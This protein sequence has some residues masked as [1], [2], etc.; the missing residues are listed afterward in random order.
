MSEINSI[1]SDIPAVAWG[2]FGAIIGA[3]I[4]FIGVLVSNYGNNNRLNIQLTHDAKEKSKDRINTLRREVYLSA[5]EEMSRASAY[6]GSIS[7][8]DLATANIAMDLQNLFASAAKLS[9]VA[10][11]KT[12]MAVNDLGMLYS[13]LLMKLMIQIEPIQQ[14]KNTISIQQ[15]LYDTAHNNSMRVMKELNAF[16]ETAQQDN[17]IFNA[18]TRS[19]ESFSNTAHYHSDQLIIA[20][21]EHCKLNF[22]FN[23]SLLPAIKE[24]GLAQVEVAICIRQ[25]LGLNT[26]A[27]E[28]REQINKQWRDVQNNLDNTLETMAKT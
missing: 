23:K 16:V 20:H 15:N 22:E 14:I 3:S 28:L 4:A 10:E 8:L 13:T 9:L 1:F 26:N 12:Q 17:Q 6:I 19:H 27:I 24:L 2:T 5:A 7:Q 18:L 21:E 11:P 25:D